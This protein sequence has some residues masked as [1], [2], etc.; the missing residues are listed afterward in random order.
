MSEQ[1]VGTRRGRKQRPVQETPRTARWLGLFILTVFILVPLASH[2]YW[3]LMPYAD[4]SM[5]VVDKTVPHTDYREHRWLFWGLDHHKVKPHGEKRGWRL[6][7]DYVGFHPTEDQN[8]DHARKDVL[9]ASDLVHS[10]ALWVADNYGVYENDFDTMRPDKTHLDYS[11]RIYG[12]FS[13]QEAGAIADFARK[14]GHVIGEFNTF[15][16]PTH[17]KA[18]QELEELFGV[19]WSGWAGR[20]F[21]DLGDDEEVP[22]WAPRNWR[23]HWNQPWRFEGPGWI[24]TH[25]DTR[26]FVLEDGKDVQEEGLTVVPRTQTGLMAGVRGPTPFDYWFDI[27]DAK[28]GTKV[29]ADF[30][31]AVTSDGDDMLERFGLRP[32]FPAVSVKST[33]PL[34][35]YMA[36]DVSDS[37]E[38][39][40]PRWLAGWAGF[41]K[42]LVSAGLGS[43]HRQFT[44]AFY[45]PLLENIVDRIEDGV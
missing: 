33:A 10:D 5:Q 3:R 31:L 43:K 8:P 40:G 32:V 36:G 39:L 4:V 35:V 26:I 14:G 2:I 7:D 20:H 44:W 21:Q 24:F 19:E 18:R 13:R 15:A 38:D 30:R 27:V 25:E 16:A 45:M 22:H 42:I 41:Q 37:S 9:E 29:V 12:G 34:R 28:R 1:E 17:G 23:R 6:A 11:R